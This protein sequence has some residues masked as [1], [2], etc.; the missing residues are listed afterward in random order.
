MEKEISHIPE[1][2]EGSR[3]KKMGIDF[4][5]MKLEKENS[6]H[7]YLLSWFQMPWLAEIRK[8]ER[9]RCSRIDSI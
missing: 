1:S 8:D 5:E 4:V 6:C 2:S 7:P 3:R 9:F